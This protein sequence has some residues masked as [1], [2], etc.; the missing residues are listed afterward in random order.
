LSII[1]LSDSGD[2]DNDDGGVGR[3]IRVII[4]NGK[5][6]RLVNK[7]MD[8]G[9]KL[10]WFKSVLFTSCDIVQETGIKTIPKKKK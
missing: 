1:R 4:A 8:P 5:H 9:A 3:R 7:L 10:S 2:E 6:L